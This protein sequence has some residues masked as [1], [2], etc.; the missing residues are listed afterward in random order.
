MF[1]AVLVVA[2][3]YDVL[4]NGSLQHYNSALGSAVMEYTVN[5]RDSLITDQQTAVLGTADDIPL[6]FTSPTYVS[7]CQHLCGSCF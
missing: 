7:K 4:T 6:I 3:V 5:D 1:G 2:T